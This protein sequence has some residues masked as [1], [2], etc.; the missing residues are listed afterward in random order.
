MDNKKNNIKNIYP[1]SPMQMSMLYHSLKIGDPSRDAYFRQ[2]VLTVK[3]ELDFDTFKKSVDI[4]VQRYDILRTAYIYEKVKQPVQ[5]VFKERPVSV[6][7]KDISDLTESEK[8]LYIEEFKNKNRNHG[9]D[10]SKSTL[11]RM[12]I[13][14]WAQKDYRIISCHHH[15]LMDG[16]CMGIV[17]GELFK[18]Y[19]AV[20]DNTPLNL[21]KVH[22]YSNYI[23]WLEK[24]DKAEARK[25]WCDYLKGYEKL[26][27]VPCSKANDKKDYLLEE[28]TFD[29]DKE[30]TLRL[31]MLARDNGITMSTVVQIL[32]GFI[33]HS[34]TETKDVIFGTVVSGRPASLEGV[35]SIVGLFINTVPVRIK[36]VDGIGFRYLAREV[37]ESILL[38]LLLEKPSLYR[39]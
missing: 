16:W 22:P 21:D 4:L 11:L 15:I 32:W 28:S 24:Q 9:F 27:T 38:V 34:Y 26:A 3:G 7:F 14:K 29:I 17:L 8:H 5:V 35:G 1:L 19:S 12:D 36:F 31:E 23:M 10:L 13:I 2:Y 6:E 18:I 30:I 39:S 37:Q 33:L 25:Y 20:L